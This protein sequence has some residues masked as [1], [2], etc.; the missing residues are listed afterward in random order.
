[1]VEELVKYLYS[2][3]LPENLAT[4]AMELLPIACE[5]DLDELIGACDYELR[6]ILSRRNAINIIKLAHRPQ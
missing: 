5:C 6:R 1:M 3:V 4:I 2:G